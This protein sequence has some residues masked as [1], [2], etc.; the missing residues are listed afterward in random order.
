[1]KSL[2]LLH[3]IS[4]I[5][6]FISCQ[7]AEENKEQHPVPKIEILTESQTIFSQGMMFD[8]GEVLQSKSVK[9]IATS[10]WIANVNPTM[11]SDWINIQPGNGDAGNITLIVTV[12][13][14]TKPEARGAFVSIKC[15]SDEKKFNV[16][17]AGVPVISVESVLLDKN[18]LA[19]V[20]GEE[21]I[22]IATVKPNNATDAFV[23]WSSADEG[24]ATVRDG[25]V[26][27]IKEGI[28]TITATAGNINSTCKVNVGR[29]RN[30]LTF[31]SEGTTTVSLSNYEDNLPNLFYSYDRVQWSQW[32]Y[33]ELTISTDTPLFIYGNNPNG[34]S[35][36]KSKYSCF[37]TQGDSFEVRGSIMSLVSSE[38]ELESIPCNYCFRALFQNCS[39]LTTAPELPA[40]TL[41]SSCY[42]GLFYNCSSLTLAPELPA[43]TLAERCYERLFSACTS[44]SAAP[45]LPA[46]SLAEY[47]YHMMFIGCTGLSVAPILP[48]TTLTKCCYFRMFEKCTRLTTSPELPATTLAERCYAEMFTDCSS[49]TTAPELPVK[50]LLSAYYCYSGMFRNCSNL[51]TP[52]ELPA[53]TLDE[54]CYG[55][56]F[57]GCTSLT[58]APALPATTLAERCYQ[59]MFIDCTS[60]T[61]APELPAETLSSAYFCYAGMFSGCT[62]LTS[63]PKLPATMLAASCYAGM[64]SGC[65]SL[66]TAPE[67]PST[68]LDVSCYSNMFENCTSL[69]SAPV[70]PA[71]NLVSGCY[72]NMFYGCS[73]LNYIKAMFLTEP[74]EGETEDWVFGVASSGTFVK[75]LDAT[76]DVFGDSGVPAGWT[77]IKQ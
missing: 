6:L 48:S 2:H 53:T 39:N 58:K 32:D 47:C 61:D 35:S 25:K 29:R 21:S 71:N 74:T 5:F 51:I 11:S 68:T 16:R 75:N 24:V 8:S 36:S 3:L 50:N 31:L 72:M 70:L 20:E 19:L 27:A 65:A 45:K 63:A 67:L 37:V 26:T 10:S 22:L 30:Y 64:F 55:G 73:E 54:Y 33:S 57:R 52:P 15:G 60:L 12:Q 4:F 66:T 14:N 56:M 17:Q 42:E 23:S 77:L 13:P 69:K 40:T 1:M 49:L 7:K 34:I 43:T 44:L 9:F 38:T 62:A 59:G 76:W 18:E 46:T 41:T 28:T